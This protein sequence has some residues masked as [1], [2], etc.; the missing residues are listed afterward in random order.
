MQP[1][2]PNPFNAGQQ[3]DPNPMNNAGG[4]GPMYFNVRDPN[5]TQK[6]EPIK[7][8]SSM[9]INVVI[10]SIILYAW[11][12]VIAIGL[13]NFLDIGLAFGLFAAFYVIYFCCSCCCSDIKE[14]INNM[15][16]FDHYQGTYDQMVKG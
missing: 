10:S 8:P 15:K 14:Y 4:W 12:I 6:N 1:M 7:Q 13:Y 9:H 11:V 5:F 16:P 2:Q 3:L